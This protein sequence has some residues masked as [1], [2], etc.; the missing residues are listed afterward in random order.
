MSETH[1]VIQTLK[2][3]LRSQKITYADVAK[4]LGMSE[5]S[6]K[7]MFST[8]HITVKRTEQICKMLNMDFMDLLRLYEEQRL[9]ISS[10]THEQELELVKDKR[11]LLVATC[12][13]NNLLFDEILE[14]FRIEKKDLYHCLARLEEMKLL[15]LH[16]FNRIK[17]LVANDFRWI[18]NG[19]IETYFERHML[20][21]F[22]AG[23]F[24]QDQ[25][26]R[27][28]LGGPLTQQARDALNYLLHRLEKQFAELL[29]DSKQSPTAHKR[30]IALLV[31][32]RAWEAPFITK[33]RISS[34]PNEETLKEKTHVQPGPA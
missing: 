27:I 13:R 1:I 14:S 29:E 7:K 21:E 2:K 6:I 19:P 22:M 9:R 11:L 18:E 10:L 32:T 8:S 34:K 30:N 5:A 17:W 31:A 4:H 33:M 12:A 3:A 25:G 24:H 26:M 23:D 20:N 15:E 28:Y 16:P